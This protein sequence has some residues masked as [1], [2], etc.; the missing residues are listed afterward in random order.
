MKKTFIIFCFFLMIG[1]ASEEKTKKI[2]KSKVVRMPPYYKNNC[3]KENE[4]NKCNIFVNNSN[5]NFA[6]F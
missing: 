6:K 4:T 1:C 5:D 2:D 3:G